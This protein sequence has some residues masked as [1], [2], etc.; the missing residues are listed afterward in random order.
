MASIALTVAGNAVL[1]GIGGL[2]GGFIGGLVDSV[3]MKNLTK[4]TGGPQLD[5]LKVMTA[6]YGRPIPYVYGQARI[7][8]NVIWSSDFIEHKHPPGGKGGLLGG[9]A[10]YTYTVDCAIAFCV[11]PIQQYLTLLA[12]NNIDKVLWHLGNR[13]WCDGIQLYTGTEDQTIDPIIESYTTASKTPAYRGTAYVRFQGLDLSHFG[14]R[15]PSVTARIIGITPTITSQSLSSATADGFQALDTGL[16]GPSSVLGDGAIVRIGTQ[17]G[18]LA[19]AVWGVAGDGVTIIGGSNI[20]NDQ[21]GL[22]TSTA[23]VT[24]AV[25]WFGYAGAFNRGGYILLNPGTSSTELVYVVNPT[26]CNVVRSG[27]AGG[28]TFCFPMSNPLS[29]GGGACMVGGYDGSRVWLRQ[30]SAEGFNFDFIDGTT[31]IYALPGYA[32]V[33][34]LTPYWNGGNGRLTLQNTA[35]PYDLKVVSISGGYR[36]SPTIGQIDS[37]YNV[38]D[39]SED[40]VTAIPVNPYGNGNYIIQSG[41]KLYGICVVEGGTQLTNTVQTIPDGWKL[42]SVGSDGLSAVFWS[43]GSVSTI[44]LTPTSFGNFLNVGTYPGAMANP[45]GPGYA[46]SPST[47]LIDDGPNAQILRL[48]ENQGLTV[49]FIVADQLIRSSLT[50]DDYDV[51]VLNQELVG[52]VITQ[53]MSARAAIEPLQGYAGFDLVETDGQLVAVLRH[54]TPDVTIADDDLGVR[55]PTEIRVVPIQVER[56]ADSDLTRILYVDFVD[57]GNNFNTNTVVAQRQNTA[58]TAVT[59]TQ[60]SIVMLPTKAQQVSEELLYDGWLQHQTVT[61]HVPISYVRVN[62]G[63]VVQAQDKIFRVENVTYGKNVI[64]IVGSPTMPRPNYALEV[65]ASPTID[66]VLSP[67]IDTPL[68]YFE[69]PPLTDG[70]NEDVPTIYIANLLSGAFADGYRG[71]TLFQWDFARL[72]WNGIDILP[73]PA[74]WGTLSTPLAALNYGRALEE[75]G[76]FI[77]PALSVGLKLASGTL[78]STTADVVRASGANAAVIYD[79]A[80]PSAGEVI[81]FTTATMVSAGQYILSGLLR[82]RRGTTPQAWAAG[83]RFIILDATGLTTLAEELSLTDNGKTLRFC[84]VT[85]GQNLEDANHQVVDFAVTGRS[86][87]C[88]PP[89]RVRSGLKS[90]GDLAISW[91]RQA[92]QA[93]QLYDHM[94]TPLGTDTDTYT[95]VVLAEDGQTVLRMLGTAATPLPGPAYTYVIADQWADA[96][97]NGGAPGTLSIRQVST[98]VG[99][100]APALWA[101]PVQAVAAPPPVTPPDTATTT[102]AATAS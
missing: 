80:F 3:I 96:T 29:G 33:R 57:A 66:I 79:P 53:P 70:A 71:G 97:A 73:Q 64:Q 32:P 22:D 78:N 98:R 42:M 91:H 59:K 14:N 75:E 50:S 5:S 101:V 21:R 44:Q 30:Y 89:V 74:T 55:G 51:S 31:D 26:T 82:G 46:I 83:A 54:G 65:Q 52:Y 99:P 93:F 48:N 23:N 4:T 88:L 95:A 45:S 67:L 72:M 68:A 40:G 102:P 77:N 76:A 18:R 24:S 37:I 61:I 41:N 11:G 60:L 10:A 35:A 1:P 27:G 34:G 17:N 9:K 87:Q 49:G 19:L 8:G 43:G 47:F 69:L 56:K 39:Y 6:D 13:Q 28:A 36:Q 85:S 84:A 12:D 100:G 7:S 25:G 86:I 92:R 58:A 2:V 81:E 62:P 20:L 94:T 63:D 16:L 15:I 90:N 38:W